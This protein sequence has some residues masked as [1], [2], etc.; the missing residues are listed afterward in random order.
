VSRIICILRFDTG[1][2]GGWRS[3]DVSPALIST[4]TDAVLDEVAEWHMRAMS[5][6]RYLQVKLAD[7]TTPA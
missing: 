1:W 7:V 4:I 6:P 2:I 5:A 3:I